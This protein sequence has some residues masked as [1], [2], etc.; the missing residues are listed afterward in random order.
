MQLRV[1]F[2]G[3]S[4]LTACAADEPQ[5][6]SRINEAYDF[7]VTHCDSFAMVT[8][9]GRGEAPLRAAQQDAKQQGEALQG[10][11][12][13]WLQEDHFDADNRVRVIAVVYKCLL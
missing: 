3:L 1:I 7:E 10:T 9:I 4:L 13:V 8:G 11:H 6:Y 12:I 2:I 5:L